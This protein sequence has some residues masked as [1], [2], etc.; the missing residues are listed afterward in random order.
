MINNLH[1]R[2][3]ID[4]G[5]EERFDVLAVD[6]DIA[7]AARDVIAVGVFFD[8]EPEFF[9]RFRDVIQSTRHSREKISP[10]N[11]VRVVDGV[12]DIILRRVPF[13]DVSIER[14]DARRQTTRASD[15]RLVD[16]QNSDV[17]SEF[18]QSN[19]GK[20]ARRAAADYQNVRCKKIFSCRLLPYMR[21]HVRVLVMHHVMFVRH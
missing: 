11:S 14:I 10:S 16:E 2:Q 3:S 15:V 18:A 13:A 7:L 1:V 6:F 19:C 8:H 20:Q 12:F 4:G 5:S 21:L 9:N 17:R